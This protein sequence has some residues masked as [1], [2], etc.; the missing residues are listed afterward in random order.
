M[1]KILT[2]LLLLL[3]LAGC[4]SGQEPD[5]TQ[6][7]NITTESG[8]IN[9]EEPLPQDKIYQYLQA[10]SQDA[11]SAYYELLEFKISNY[12]ESAEDDKLEA[13]FNYT[14][15]YKNFDKDPDTVEYIKKAKEDNDPYYQ[16]YY[17]EYLQPKEMNLELRAIINGDGEISLY[18]DINPH[19][20]REWVE[21]EM[22][23]IV[24]SES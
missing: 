14:I 18:T 15:T 13:I 19:S 20:E 7:S 1:K 5:N 3:L 17:D 21:F 16:T 23:D 24:L 22:S 12:E 4:A 6:S 2:A 8:T 9:E 11:L 10:E